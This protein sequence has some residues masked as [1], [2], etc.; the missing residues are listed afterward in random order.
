MN[1]QDLVFVDDDPAIRAVAKL[2]LERGSRWT[3]H[4]CASGEEALELARSLRPGVIV[5]DLM[6]PGM[7]GRETLAA[8]QADPQLSGIPVIDLTARVDEAELNQLR[9]TA[10]VIG[11]L[12]KPFDA[13]GLPAEVD[14]LLGLSE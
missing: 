14:A 7:D 3:V 8:L 1:S 12:S 2:S 10:G 9:S 11:V 5:L 4:A 6:M 13:G